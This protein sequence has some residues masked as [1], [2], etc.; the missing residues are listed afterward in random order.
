MKI[1]FDHKIFYHQNAG[2]ISRYIINLSKQFDEIGINNFISSPIHFNTMLR[3][4]KKFKDDIFAVYIKKKP[5]FTNYLFN[6]LNNKITNFNSRKF[7]PNVY[8]QTYYGDFLCKKKTTKVVTVHDLIHEKFH[9]DYGFDKNWRPKKKSLDQADKIIC[10]SENTK[11]DLKKYYNI[12]NKEIEVI[13]HG[14]DHLFSEKDSSKKKRENFILY[15]GGRDKY[16][17][18]MGFIESYSNSYELKKNFKIVCF[19]GGKFNIIEQEIFKKK[20]IENLILYK[21]GSDENLIEL[22]KKAA[23]LVYPSLY[24]GFGIPIIEAMSFGCPV[25]ASN[26]ISL[27]ES[28]GE[29]AFIFDQNNSSEISDAIIK[30]INSINDYKISPGILH[31]KKFTWRKCAEKTLKLYER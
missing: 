30:A 12:N 24:E 3:D 29:A 15:I 27:K 22:Y 11:N 16:K 6:I 23:C 5:R 9:K 1:F 28:C 7:D 21:Q 4:Y 13:Y 8:H 20:K 19:G 26:S 2:G 31:A 25:A 17:N 14:Y 10:V 18:F